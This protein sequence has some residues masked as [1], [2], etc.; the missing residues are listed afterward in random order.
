MALRADLV[1]IFFLDFLKHKT[2]NSRESCLGTR[3]ALVPRAS[4]SV[5]GQIWIARLGFPG[6]PR[7]V[8]YDD[9]FIYS[10]SNCAVAGWVC[11]RD[12]SE[13]RIL[14]AATWHLCERPSGS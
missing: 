5:C 2:Q 7:V 8:R 6:P 14:R 10:A 13:R 3:K 1:T 11:V 12:T 4:Y 9:I